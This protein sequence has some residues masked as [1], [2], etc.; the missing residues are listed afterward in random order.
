MRRTPELTADGRFRAFGFWVA[1][2]GALVAL[3][4]MPATTD[5]AWDEQSGFA[6]VAALLGVFGWVLLARA[7]FRNATQ[8]R[9]PGE[10]GA[11]EHSKLAEAL[12]EAGLPGDDRQRGLGGLDSRVARHTALAVWV[13]SVAWL[14]LDGDDDP[15]LVWSWGFMPG[16]FHFFTAIGYVWFNRGGG[17][18]LLQLAPITGVLHAMW[19]LALGFWL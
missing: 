6:F 4:V 11:G 10:L 16:M 12:G 3:G 1:G 17:I 15:S 2:L 13:V 19:F 7:E 8:R 18:S 5:R 14:G 9:E